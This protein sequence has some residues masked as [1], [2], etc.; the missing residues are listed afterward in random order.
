MRQVYNIQL[1][2]REFNGRHHENMVRD[3]FYVR[4]VIMQTNLKFLLV[5]NSD[6]WQ[7]CQNVVELRQNKYVH[8]SYALCSLYSR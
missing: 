5:S 2:L 3:V 6:Y 4:G 8:K 7:M 1:W